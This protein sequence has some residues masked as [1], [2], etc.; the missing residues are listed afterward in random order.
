[1]FRSQN[2]FAQSALRI[3]IGLA[4][5]IGVFGLVGQGLIAWREPD[6]GRSLPA[7]V[8]GR[9]IEVSG[10]Q[11]HVVEAGSGP[12][13]L[14][15]HGFGASTQDFEQFV[16]E[17]LAQTHHV[18]ALDLYGFGWSERRPDFA[19]GWTLWSDQLADTLDVLGV[20]RAT[21]VGHS[22]GG[23][24]ATVFAARYPDRVAGLIL[25]DSFY[26][27]EPAERPT[28]FTLLQVPLLG[29]VM[30]GASETSAAPGFS[31][32]YLARAALW[33]RIR[34]TRQAA[35]QY[36]RDPGKLAELASAYPDVHAPTLIL[37]G[38]AD[39]FVPIA[40]MQRWAPQIADARIV[41]IV[42]GSHFILRDKSVELLDAVTAFLSA[43]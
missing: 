41:T 27:L 12:T 38:T 8:P 5:V 30:L 26:P 37:H 23:A 10:R 36:V 42:D 7:G 35:L 43:P 40:A 15:V 13:L 21:V 34:G 14:L 29:E 2:P 33:S 31:T 11:V 1:M 28:V 25:A 3:L 17:P 24:V 4:L 22:M 19:Y 9:L 39:V 6:D 32:D 18:V 20:E 16:L